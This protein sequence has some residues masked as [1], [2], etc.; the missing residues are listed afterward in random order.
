ML[1]YDGAKAEMLNI[2]DYD[3]R[4]RKTVIVNGRPVAGPFHSANPSVNNI[5]LDGSAT[6]P[7]RTR[8]PAI[9]SAAGS[10]RTSTIRS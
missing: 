8:P 9:P 1:A 4:Y 6:S 2:P 7:A 3:L 5:W 10:T